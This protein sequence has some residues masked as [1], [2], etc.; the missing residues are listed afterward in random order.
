MCFVSHLFHYLLCFL[1]LIFNSF[2]NWLV[3]MSKKIV[4]NGNRNTLCCTA[5]R[6]ERVG[7]GQV[8]RHAIFC[9]FCTY[10]YGGRDPVVGIMGRPPYIY[11]PTWSVWSWQEQLLWLN[12]RSYI[13]LVSTVWSISEIWERH[14]SQ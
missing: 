14:G 10:C 6:A 1:F 11:Q 12:I 8:S 2:L 7:A 3:T 4:E 13:L 5:N 9:T